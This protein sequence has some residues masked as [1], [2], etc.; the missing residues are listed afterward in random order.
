MNCRDP[1]E[2]FWRV[3]GWCLV[4]SLLTGVVSCTAVEVIRAL[5]EVVGAVQEPLT[6]H[7]GEAL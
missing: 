5:K 3:L 6:T 1:E 2:T 7:R 4:I